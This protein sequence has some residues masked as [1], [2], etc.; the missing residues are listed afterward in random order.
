MGATTWK[1]P[2][3]QND[4]AAITLH[5]SSAPGQG[6]PDDTATRRQQFRSMPCNN[7]ANPSEHA[8][9]KPQELGK[10][11]EITDLTIEEMSGT[12]FDRVS[13]IVE[14]FDIDPETLAVLKG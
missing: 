3:R 10:D 9:Y 2:L 12:L 14:W 6:R 11:C 13:N 1:E 7:N 4:K 5:A 8:I